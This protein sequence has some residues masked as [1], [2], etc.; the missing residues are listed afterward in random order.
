VSLL[1]ARQKRDDAKRLLYKGINPAEQRRLD[2]LEAEN[3]ARQTFG[4]VADEYIEQMRT[5]GAA[6]STITKTTWL[7]KD[8]ASP[9][10]DRPIRE[11]QAAEILDLLKRIEKSGRWETAKRLRGTISSVF[12]LAIVTLRAERL[13][14]KLCHLSFSDSL[15]GKW[16]SS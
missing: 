10:S 14:N 13:F 7:L 11:I 6:K 16:I 3:T 12:R 4:L 8:L 5:R 9:L 15:F 2:K 1:D